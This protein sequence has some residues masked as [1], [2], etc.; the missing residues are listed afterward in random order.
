MQAM[1][2]LKVGILL[3]VAMAV[4]QFGIGQTKK[5]LT[6]KKPNLRIGEKIGGMAGNLMTAKTTEL[7][8]TA[9]IVSLIVGVYNPDAKTSEARYFPKGTQ[10]GDHLMYCTFMKQEGMG[11]LKVSGQIS[12]DEDSMEY[13]GVGSYGVNFSRPIEGTKT[14]NIKSESGQTARI[15][16][17]PIP[18]VEILD[19]NGD[20]GMPVLDLNDDFTIRITHP[21][22]SDGTTI[23]VGL[24][25]D[26]AGARAWN[27]FADFKA[28]GDR[29]TIPKEA[30]SNLE[31]NGKLGAGQV[32]KGLNYIV[33]LRE[34][35]IEYHEEKGDKVSGDCARVKIQV[36]AYG[37]KPVIVK[38][39]QEEGVLTEIK[40]S[41]RVRNKYAFSIYKPNARTGIPL[42]RASNFGLASLTVNGRT[43]RKETKSGEHT[44]T[45]MG[46]R[47]TKTWTVT[48][49]YKFPQLP[50][51]HW[52]QVMD[53]FY[54]SWTDVLQT[55]YNVSHVPIEAITNNPVYQQS[56]TASDL[57]TATK[58]SKSY[59]YTKRVSPGHLGSVLT[60]LS[61]EG[62]TGLMGQSKLD[63]LV[64]LEINFDIGANK[65][66]KIVLLPTVKFSVR[67]I[68]ETKNNR[69]GVYAEGFIT[70]KEGVPFSSEAVLANPKAL[71][72]VLNIEELMASISIML[73]E[74]RKKEVEM[75]Y[76]KIWSIGE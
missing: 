49:T 5:K 35:V 8:N 11:M 23:K 1:R 3:V 50:D 41:G 51:S 6:L 47:Y 43:Y 69:Q 56:F 58:V 27:Y 57:N 63:G 54:N 14:I 66:K 9:P 60:S 32:N 75:G 65:D 25:T 22:G 21:E 68:D 16:V 2:N 44:Y 73:D 33:V 30:F 39:K 62:V 38:G 70:L 10:E 37:T 31:I 61:A 15:A 40:F 46:T 19:I 55:K 67:G 52:E 76:D 20:W 17:D 71:S 72:E 29:I 53:D 4:T 26:V 18:E 12:C 13:V 64:S 24:L 34:K 7:S 48:T 28:T 45:S 36:K 42:S 59:R 74:L